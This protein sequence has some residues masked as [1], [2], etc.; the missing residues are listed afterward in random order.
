M[1]QNKQ[2]EELRDEDL[3]EPGIAKVKED[4]PKTKFQIYCDEHPDAVECKI[5]DD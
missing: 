1:Y 3:N 2:M 4:H 5:F